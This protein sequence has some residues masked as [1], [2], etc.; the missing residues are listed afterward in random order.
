M[1]PTDQYKLN[2]K[3]NES[4]LNRKKLNDGITLLKMALAQY[5]GTNWRAMVLTDTLGTP[6]EPTAFYHDSK[7]A[8][9]QRNESQLLN[10]S[11]QAEKL[12]KKMTLGEALPSL[13]VGGS[14]SYHTILA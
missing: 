3:K 5:I 2:L 11:L 9:A 6:S 13:M 4:Q 14:T 1:M 12:K 7:T 10:L 8:V